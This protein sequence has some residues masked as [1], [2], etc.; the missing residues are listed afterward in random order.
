M[1]VLV[2]RWDD[3]IVLG[4][5]PLLFVIPFRCFCNT[6]YC[7]RLVSG[8]GASRVVLKL[9]FECLPQKETHSLAKFLGPDCHTSIT[10]QS[11]QGTVIQSTVVNSSLR[12][13]YFSV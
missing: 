1:F 9:D 12:V 3:V 5:P 10:Y 8:E 4:I 11:G 2:T 13:R 6:F 7:F